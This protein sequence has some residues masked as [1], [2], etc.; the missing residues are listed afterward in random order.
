ME[1]NS[2]LAET[3]LVNN[4]RKLTAKLAPFGGWLM[5]IQ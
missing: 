2:V 3:P 4:H 5:P 1:E